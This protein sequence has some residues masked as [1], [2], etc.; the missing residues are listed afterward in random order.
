MP[1]KVTIRALLT[2]DLGKKAADAMAATIDKMIS[3]K[4]SAAQIERAIQADLIKHTAA[5]V[6]AAMAR[7]S[8]PIK[9]SVGVEAKIGVCSRVGP[10]IKVH[11]EPRIQVGPGPLRKG[12]K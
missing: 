4:K 8:A 11:V 12:P 7:A 2:K 3:E 1:A 5:Q 9:S 10:Q 6:T